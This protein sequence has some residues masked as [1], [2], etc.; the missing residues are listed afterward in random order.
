MKVKTN[1]R[2]KKRAVPLHYHLHNFI[3]S[4]IPSDIFIIRNPA[5]GIE[6]DG[7]DKLVVTQKKSKRLTEA[8]KFGFVNHNHSAA[9]DRTVTNPNTSD[10]NKNLVKAG[11][12][13]KIASINEKEQ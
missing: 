13:E 1:P 9:Q 10:L 11:E 7:K 6:K 3:M 4:R 12:L 8:V 2:L 5:L